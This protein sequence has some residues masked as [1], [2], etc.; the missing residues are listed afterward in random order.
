MRYRNHL[1]I[2]MP[3][4]L[5]TGSVAPS[6]AGG[7]GFGLGLGLGALFTADIIANSY[8]P[9]YPAPYYPY[10][11]YN[12]A[13]PYAYPAPQPTVNSTDT[14][15][16]QAL[17]AVPSTREDTSRYDLT[18][19]TD[20]HTELLALLDQKLKDGDITKGQS[21]AEV[22]ALDQMDRLARA[23]A[24][25]QGGT[26]TGTQERALVVQFQQAYYLINHNFVVTD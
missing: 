16:R 18:V 15:P 10:Y 2:V 26:L 20:Y 25:A 24:A 7:G 23:E 21:A 17:P 4:L 12:S 13:A 1:K 11:P 3:V 8:P 14:P 9:Y 19:V 5:L 22:E 6:W